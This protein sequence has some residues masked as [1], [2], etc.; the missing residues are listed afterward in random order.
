MMRLKISLPSKVIYEGEIEKISFEAVDGAFT[1]LPRH[2][3]FVTILVA[4]ILFF[5]T[6]GPESQEVFYAVD[7]G[8]LTKH[9]RTVLV[10]THNAVRSADLE[11][12]HRTILDH[13]ENLNEH[14][15]RAY[16]ALTR[17]EADFVRRYL[18]V[19]DEI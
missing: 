5:D 10:S 2:I 12:L 13:F 11:S 18:E 17:L 14:E 6:T 19:E 7:Q 4:G 3:D 8:I 1:M 16:S 15:R 9:G